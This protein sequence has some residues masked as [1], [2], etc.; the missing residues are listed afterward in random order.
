MNGELLITCLLENF[1]NGIENPA[2]DP[3]ADVSMMNGLREN[4][5]GCGYT[6]PD[7]IPME[8]IVAVQVI[9]LAQ[10]LF[11]FFIFA[12]RYEIFMLWAERFH[13]TSKKIDTTEDLS[14]SA[15]TGGGRTGSYTNRIG[16]ASQTG[17]SSSTLG[18][19]A[20]NSPINDA[21][22]DKYA[23]LNGDD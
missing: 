19:I 11:L 14:S 17:G 8:S 13:L 23:Q 21:K 15:Q 6:V 10:G 9:S 18:P 5:T 1:A 20:P 7:R 12:F 3:R 4:G 2:E 16:A 22:P